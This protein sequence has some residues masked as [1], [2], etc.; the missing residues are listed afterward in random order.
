MANELSALVRF[1]GGSIDDL[2]LTPTQS[3]HAA[4]ARRVF[5]SL[6][7]LAAPAR[8]LHDHV[9]ATGYA[10]LRG[11]T[12]VGTGLAAASIRLTTGE[13]LRMLSRSRRGRASIS[14][15]NALA[16]DMMEKRGN[17]LAIQMS[18]CANAT[19]IPCERSR[20]RA[21]FP[22]A[23]G[24]IAVFLHGLGETPDAWQRR[25]HQ[26]FGRRLRRDVGITPVYLRYNTG[27]HISD[28]GKQ[29][30]DLLEELID[31][32]PVRVTELILIGHSMGGLVA[33]SAC[34]AGTVAARRWPSKVKH[35]ITLGSP[36]TGVPLEKLVHSTAW[37]LRV[38]PESKPLADI[39]DRRSAGIRDLRFGYLVEDDWKGE[40]PK[41][42]LHDHR[43]HV[44]PLDGCTH[45][46]IS[47]SVSESR[48][49]LAWVAGDLLVRPGSAAGRGPGGTV[50]VHSDN[51]FH[52]GALNH[53]DLLD[54]P[55][56]YEHIRR[57]VEQR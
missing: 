41:R 37:M 14:A 44:P 12:D 39:L 26:P 53:F 19:G 18:V 22:K 27:L 25:H 46:F 48:H 10:A 29:L 9:A 1:A 50:V 15:L 23:T 3:L 51:V 42:L 16:G 30:S 5:S 32:W 21:E 38:V 17:E 31:A 43:S 45:T 33:R 36:H 24:R 35:L 34:Y 7:P 47:A 28:N 13:D 8:F 54:H 4:V 6:G 11:A 56:V 20:L 2:V 52:V 57:V 55:I 40:D 49:P